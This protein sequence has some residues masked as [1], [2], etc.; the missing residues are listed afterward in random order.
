MTKS[1]FPVVIRAVTEA[2]KAM[3]APTVC[4]DA[5]LP[6]WPLPARE[7]M[8]EVGMKARLVRLAVVTTG[9]IGMV[10]ALGAPKKW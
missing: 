10:A 4:N 3:S 9:V 5:H 6:S 8:K 2:P 1:G 7:P